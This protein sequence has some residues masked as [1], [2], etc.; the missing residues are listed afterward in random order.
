MFKLFLAIC[1]LF[2]EN[3][4]YFQQNLKYDK[5]SDSYKFDNDVKIEQFSQL[6]KTHGKLFSIGMCSYVKDVDLPTNTRMGRYCSIAPGVRSMG[7]GRHPQN[8]FTTS[9]VSL[10]NP[11]EK[12]IAPMFVDKKYEK[13]FVPTYFK[14]KKLPIIIG[15]DVW[16]GNDVI[17]K[18]GVKVGNGAIIAQGSIVTK[19]V[20]PYAL[21]AGVPGVVKR[22]RFSKS[23]IDTLQKIKWWE[24]AYWDFDGIYGAD[25]IEVFLD[26]FQKLIDDGNLKK[27]HPKYVTGKD[28]LRTK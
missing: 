6:V 16:I 11:S 22:Y 5:L 17:I 4:V 12:G 21:V 1:H 14:Q 3:N 9:P 8:R 24:Y 2:K 27:H 18:Q 7:G 26:K 13:G 25:K 10:S 19:N 20:P 15:N 23:I 28:I